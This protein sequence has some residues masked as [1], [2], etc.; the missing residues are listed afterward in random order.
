MTPRLVNNL[1]SDWRIAR[2]SVSCILSF[3]LP[4]YL[5]HTLELVNEESE[6]K[7]SA[8]FNKDFPTFLEKGVFLLQSQLVSLSGQKY[9]K[10]NPPLLSN[11]EKRNKYFFLSGAMDNECSLGCSVQRKKLCAYQRPISMNLII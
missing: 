4:H 10:K 9:F 2:N 7:F 3:S 6:I 1:S 11:H 5:L 8:P